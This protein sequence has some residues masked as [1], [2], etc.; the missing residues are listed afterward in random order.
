[1]IEENGRNGVDVLTE[2]YDDECLKRGTGVVVDW[3]AAVETNVVVDR[4]QLS[5]NEGMGEW[6]R[7][8]DALKGLRRSL[9]M[10]AREVGGGVEGAG[11]EWQHR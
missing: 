7:Y 4:R 3:G 10:A 5:G 9:C 1:M 6:K 2:E 11:V 8:L